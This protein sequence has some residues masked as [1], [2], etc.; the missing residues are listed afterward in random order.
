MEWHQE[1]NKNM[2]YSYFSSIFGEIEFPDCGD[3]TMTCTFY[4]TVLYCTVINCTAI[5]YFCPNQGNM[6]PIDSVEDWDMV[7][8]VETLSVCI[9]RVLNF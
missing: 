7:G 6:N 4:C 3:N 8:K 9:S 2:K 5:P 1:R